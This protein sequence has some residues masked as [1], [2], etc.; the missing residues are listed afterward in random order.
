MKTSYPRLALACALL[1]VAL[2]A[3]CRREAGREVLRIR[4]RHDL[5]HL[6]VGNTAQLTAFQEYRGRTGESG[7]ASAGPRVVRD[8]LHERVAALWSVSDPALASIGEGGVIT[9]LKP[10]R[11]TIRSVWENREASTTVEL[12]GGLRPARLPQIELRGAAC[13]P[14]SI[15]LRLDDKRGLGFHLS[16]DEGDCQ[17]VAL[18]TRAPDAPLPWELPF[19]GGTLRVL[20]AR[21]H[22]ASG[23]TRLEG[24]GEVWFTLWSEGAGA[25]PV[26]LAGKTVL[27]VGDSMAEGL[28]PSLQRRVEAAGGRFFVD[29]WQGSTII[30]W[31]GTG[32][33]KQMLERYRPDTVFIAL[34][35]NELQ[36]RK[37]EGRA[38]L[39]KRMVLEIGARPAYW[40][41]PP[42][43]KPDK[44]LLGVIEENFQPGH[45][46]NASNLQVE[47][48]RDGKHPTLE[49]FAQWAEL[50]W[51]W[52]TL[53][54][55]DEIND[56]AS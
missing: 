14:Q 41:G 28:R 36:T 32:R 9:A 2:S 42:S 37:P 17:D 56:T 46:Y 39:I 12:V 3:S 25:F 24:G 10:G 53:I 5:T 49:G 18:E 20:S 55:K 1:F 15:E 34:G 7:V 48:Q 22:V 11:V 19:N 29:P 44:G 50:V 38:P 8:V 6:A 21:G 40:I 33:L 30:G 13:Q 52:F 26:S 4:I 23:V 47:R 35:S 45:F 54:S 27:L 43:W 16:F 31:E 51:D